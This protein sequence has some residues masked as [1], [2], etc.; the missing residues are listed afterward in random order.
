[1]IVYICKQCNLLQCLQMYTMEVCSTQ[2]NRTAA[3]A[4]HRTRKIRMFHARHT[5]ARHTRA[6]RT[7]ARLAAFNGGS[8]KDGRK[9]KGRTERRK[10]EPPPARVGR[11]VWLCAWLAGGRANHPRT[12]DATAARPRADARTGEPQ[13]RKGCPP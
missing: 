7:T 4:R 2:P 3:T 9:R 13:R 8:K 6:R 10:G 5:H 12:P 11:G 1:M